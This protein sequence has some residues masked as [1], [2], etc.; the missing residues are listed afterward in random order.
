MLAAILAVKLPLLA[1]YG[2]AFAPD[3]G[4]YVDYARII[5]NGTLGEQRLEHHTGTTVFRAIGYPA[6]IAAAIWLVGESWQWLVVALQ[7]ALTLAAAVAVFR[8]L[9]VLVRNMRWAVAGGVAYG[10]SLPLVLDQMILT[11][12]LAASLLAI[13]ACELARHA[14]AAQRLDAAT[15][16]GLGLLLA[17]AFLIREATVLL[18]GP[19][20][21]P[22]ALLAAAADRLP[23]GWTGLRSVWPRA[24]LGAVLVLLPMLAAQQ[25]YRLW[26]QQ[27]LG[28]ALV[29]TA[30]QTT[31][32]QALTKVARD[33]PGFFDRAHPFD[34]AAADTFK[35]WEFVET[36]ELSKLLHARYGWTADRIAAAAYDSY[37]RAWMR[38]PLAMLGIP[39]SHIRLAVLRAPM[40]PVAS[41]Q[42]LHLW[43]T[44]TPTLLGERRALAAGRWDLLP[45]VILEYACRVVA[46][47]IAVA[48][49]FG[50]PWRLWRAGL[51]PATAAAAG[52]WLLLAGLYGG[53]AM[54]HF[55]PRYITGAVAGM[56]AIGLWQLHGLVAWLRR[57]RRTA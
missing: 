25:A 5:L 55:E 16:L 49:L 53:Y 24:L 27:R 39:L 8:L 7:I 22:L 48:F 41:I 6:V 17:V 20:I 51:T 50:T 47:T 35:T 19:A 21:L 30:A 10:I 15:A 23:G 43:K 44:D 28:V 4:G 18:A 14:A 31:V 54:V 11:D 46:I 12:S 36:W 52:L 1:V 56:T 32:P 57:G 9:A 38:E 37:F 26:N 13:A 34:A 2:P 40:Q 45:S 29:T 3:S 33:R 42:L